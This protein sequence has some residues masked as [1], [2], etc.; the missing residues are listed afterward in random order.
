MRERLAIKLGVTEQ[1]Q[2]ELLPSGRQRRYDNRVG[3]AR[4]YLNKAGLIKTI[5]R[6][7]Y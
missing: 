6:G 4:T 1:E 7:V 5:R 2:L 3:W